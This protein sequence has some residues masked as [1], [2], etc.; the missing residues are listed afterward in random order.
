MQQQVKR[1]TVSA[2]KLQ[3][4]TDKLETHSLQGFGNYTKQYITSHIYA[5][6]LIVTVVPDKQTSDNHNHDILIY[7]TIF[8]YIVAH[9]TCMISLISHMFIL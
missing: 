1:N 6:C 2:S 5:T 7:F 9:M 3:G 8:Y 4:M